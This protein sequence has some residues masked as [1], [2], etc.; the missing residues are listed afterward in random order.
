MSPLKLKLPR[1]LRRSCSR[2]DS[3]A[4]GPS[5]LG[6][7]HHVLQRRVAGAQHVQ[8]LLGEVADAQALAFGDGAGQRL[9]LARDG[10]DQRR[11]A[12]AVGAQDADALARLHRAVDLAHDDGFLAVLGP[13]AKRG[14]GDRP[15][16]GWADWS[17][18]LNS[19]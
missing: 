13:V 17:G 2:P 6:Q 12:L 10:L 19:N 15:A 5:V 11:L 8:F 14:V 7:A 18:S 9:H 3:R 1:K 16:W 4:L